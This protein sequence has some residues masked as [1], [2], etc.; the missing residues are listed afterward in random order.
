VLEGDAGEVTAPEESQATAEYCRQTT[1]ATV[2]AAVE[3]LVGGFPDTVHRVNT[4]RLTQDVFVRHLYKEDKRNRHI[5]VQSL[6]TDLKMIKMCIG[7]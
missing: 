3:A 2:L 4:I 6:F 1:V 7:L 5:Y